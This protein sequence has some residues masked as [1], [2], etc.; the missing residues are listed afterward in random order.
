MILKITGMSCISCAKNIESKI[1]KHSKVSLVKVD[2]VNEKIFVEGKISKKEVIEI[3]E[4]LG[5]KAFEEK[6]TLKVKG[7]NS[8][9]C[10]GII[11]KILKKLKAKNI[12]IE[13]SNEKVSFI[14]SVSFKKIKK[15]IEKAGYKVFKEEVEV[16]EEKMIKKTRNK[17]FISLTLSAILMSMM[18]WSFFEL[19]IIEAVLA[20]M[21][22]Y[23]FGF[24]VHLSAI[25]AVR[26]FYINMDV[27]ISLGDNVAY[28][29]GLA[30]FFIPEIP[31]FFSVAAFIM[32]FHLLGR[33][34]EKRARGKTS[35]ALKD[36]LKLESK[37]A[38]IL[39]NGKEKEISIKELKVGDI[40]VI[41]P[42]EKIP[43]DGKIIK[44]Q[45]YVDESMATGESLPV[46]KKEK[47]NVLGST[48]NQQGSLNVKVTK[49][50]KDTFLS[51]VI[52]LVE[53][54]QRSRVPIQ[55]LADKVTSY[56]VP[57]VLLIAI[58]TFIAW[59]LTGNW[60]I[61]VVSAMTVLIIACPCALG[62]ATPT[63]LT[64]GI[65]RG[66]KQG[67]LIRRGEAI[68]LMGK[69]KTIVLDKTGTLTKGK[70]TVTDIITFGGIEKKE[71]LKITASAEKKSEHPL[72]NSIVK[73]AEEEKIELVEIEKFEALFGRGIKAEIKG[74]KILVGKRSL[75]ENIDIS[76]AEPFLKELEKEGKTAILVSD[77]KNLLGI[78]A[79]ADTLKKETLSAIES[80]HKMGF[81]TVM[82]TG[83]NQRTAEAIAKK[84][85]IDE[86]IA[87]VLPDQKA[88]II[89]KMQKENRVAMVGDGINDAPALTQ[90]DVGI[91]I[92]SGSD[93]AIEAGEITLVKGELDALV[94]A[95][96]LSKATFKIIRENLFWAFLYNSL[97]LPIAAFGLLATMWG[98]I[99][100]AAAMAFSSFS[101]VVN[102]LRL[103]KIKL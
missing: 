35:E 31:V 64:V 46:E 7:M 88:E 48:L 75:M 69:T 18:F 20:F 90:A 29:F 28:F 41:K 10:A 21:V 49:I 5:Y 71:L 32:S 19:P 34:L 23:F 78:I 92:G 97:A 24:S 87:E 70:P 42:G 38:R 30:A 60:F 94:K 89:K 66:A 33:Y 101:V 63:A 9:H 74:R 11:E 86:V 40:M 80:L 91:A 16:E 8:P 52:K 99:I 26:N 56:F 6:T 95:I 45:S 1:K 53:E 44:G 15:E 22:V 65:G 100:A 84:I 68:E 50:G 72:A 82:L 98:P 12:N 62:L 77:N 37:K 93:I 102:S 54:A 36:L 57:V 96:K 39:E 17:T 47:D 4:S 2:F 14:S 81:K 61:A 51:Q 58:V 67:I 27:L 73:K 25:K 103:K 43:T 59:G 55:E 85:K 79:V 13:F 83:D 3:I 76:S